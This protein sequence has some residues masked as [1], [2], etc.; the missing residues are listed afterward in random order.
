MFKHESVVLALLVPAGAFLALAAAPGGGKGGGKDEPEEVELDEA[1]VFIEWNSTD[2]DFG[3]QFFWDGDGWDRMRVVNSEG[4]VALQVRARDNL[5]EQGLTEGAFE[6]VEPDPDELSMEEFLERF[7]EGEYEFEGKTLEGENL[8]G[9]TEFTHVIPAPPANL[10]P[11][12]GS[13]VSAALPLVA[14]FDAVTA[15]IDGNTLEPELYELVI[16]DMN[17]E[18]LAFT[19]VLEGDLANPSVTVPP[20][21]LEPGSDY[22]L[23]V[24]V[25][26]ESHNRTITETKFTTN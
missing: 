6:S 13:V 16:E 20:E 24:L 9:E 11:A 22:K 19:I 17:D 12:E 2:G 21:F 15:D 25:Q 18:T 14:S 4:K 1:E 7:P 10:W 26:E 23:E 8:E 5:Q 3:I